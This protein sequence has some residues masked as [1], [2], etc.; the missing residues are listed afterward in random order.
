MSKIEIREVDL[1]EIEQSAPLATDIVYV[2]GFSSLGNTESAASVGE[3]TLCTTVAEFVNKFGERPAVFKDDQ[4]YPALVSSEGFSGNAIPMIG[5]SPA[6]MFNKGDPDPSYIYAKE[7]LALGIPVVYERVNEV[8]D[9]SVGTYDVTVADMYEFLGT[10]FRYSNSVDCNTNDAVVVSVNKNKFITNFKDVGRYKFTN[11]GTTAVNLDYDYNGTNHQSSD[12]FKGV[13][14]VDGAKFTTSY[15]YQNNASANV[16]EF[17]ATVSGSTVTWKDGSTTVNFT[18]LGISYPQ[19]ITVEANDTI[20]VKTLQYGWKNS[21]DEK[22]YDADFMGLTITSGT[23]STDPATVVNI[24]VFAICA[25]MMHLDTYISNFAAWVSAV[26]FAYITNKL[27][28]FE[29]KTTD[30]K[31]LFREIVSFTGARVLTLGIDMVLMFVGVDILHINKLIVKVL[32]NVVVIV[33]N[34][35]LSK[36]F[37]FKKSAC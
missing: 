8:T 23:P 26:I 30:A 14:T 32:A 7:L 34:Y 29:S 15:P 1:T 21:V 25:D 28:V 16:H 27:W 12:K 20:V 24:V 5:S 4:V 2:P 9:I 10:N 17:K 6:N 35:V 33:S 37:I 11:V 31:E 3:P 22:I 18:T 19:S 13:V 36:L